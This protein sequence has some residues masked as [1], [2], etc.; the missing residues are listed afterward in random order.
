MKC[1]RSFS[2]VVIL[3]G[4]LFTS[5]GGAS[6]GKSPTT[7][8]L[9]T[10]TSITNITARQFGRQNLNA[11]GQQALFEFIRP[12]VRA[13][14]DE[15][16]VGDTDG[17]YDPSTSEPSVSTDEPQTELAGEDKQEEPQQ[18]TNE[19]APRGSERLESKFAW[20]KK[21][22][23]DALKT[24]ISSH[25]V[26][27]LYADDNYYDSSRL[28]EFVERGRDTIA[29]RAGVEGD[30]IQVVYGGYRSVPQVEYWI[31]PRGGSVPEF[32]P[33]DRNR[34]SEPE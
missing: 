13:K 11:G 20:A 17:G 31:V 9:T 6:V 24:D 30:Q 12:E 32:K 4:L 16:P 18:A 22:F 15:E 19:D 7:G 34:P 27:V 28:M 33:E 8:A 3:T 29:E 2:I 21:S 14:L 26:I 10:N 25:G 23:G 5:C 1:F